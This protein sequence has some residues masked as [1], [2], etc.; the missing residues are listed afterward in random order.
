MADC[1]KNFK[2]GDDSYLSH[3]SL[4]SKKIDTLITSRNAL[5]EKI[6]AYL[7]EKGVKS[8]RF[9]RQGSYAH[10]T[11]IDPLDGDYDIDDG[12]YLD[13]S[14]FDDEPS[15]RTIHNWIV[16]AA[17]GHTKEPSKDKEACVRAIFKA[18][19]HVDLPAYK[20]V[21]KED[22]TETYYLAKK[23]AGWEE[24]DP[25]AMTAWFENQI[26]QNSKQVRRIVKYFKGWRDFRNTKTQTRLLSGVTLTILACE[27]YKGD[28]RDDIVFLETGRAILSRLR[29]NDEI[30]KP[31]EPPEN[32]RDHLSDTQFEH[33]LDELEK[34]VSS[35]QEALEEESQKKAAEKWQKVLGERFPVFEDSDD[36][37]SSKAKRFGTPAIIGSTVRSA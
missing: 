24:S 12:I 29:L 20:A 6:R 32:M 19:Y 26:K 34:L 10:G 31:Y 23:T 36:D 15:T 14:G 28:I 8:P 35:G 13:L 1:S 22:D 18:G 17:E 21:E 25:R 9:Y 7:M 33:F 37:D 2:N 5:R 4:D 27:E 16:S 11:L 3:I 30:W